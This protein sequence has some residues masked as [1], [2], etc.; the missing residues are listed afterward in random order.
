VT[1]TVSP[2]GAALPVFGVA[3]ATPVGP[4][5]LPLPGEAVGPTAPPTASQA[6]GTGGTVSTAGGGGAG[7]APAGETNAQSAVPGGEGPIPEILRSSP[8]TPAIALI[9]LLTAMLLGAGHAVTPGHGKTLMA[10]YLVGTRGTPRH[11]VGLGLAVSVSHTAGILALAVVVIGAAGVLPPDLVVRVAPLIAA[12]TILAIGG[13]MLITE[14]RRGLAGRRR[15]VGAAHVHGHHDKHEQ[16]HEQAHEHEQARAHEH[17]HRPSQAHAHEHLEEH[18]LEHSHG[19]VRHRHVPPAGATITWRSLFVLGLAGGLIPSTNA[20]LILLA[21][22]ASGRPAWGV[23]LVVAFGLGMA[24]VMT[25]VGLA[26]VYARGWLEG[27]G[28]RTRLA[29][30]I[31]HVPMAAAVLVLVV[32][33]GLTTQAIA[34]VSLR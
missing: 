6:P 11:A 33:I 16:A 13:W 20:L 29:G 7:S 14:L 9:A 12:G 18:D 28:T 24:G 2:G 27:M 4:I 15:A 1:F 23:V 32:G 34:T 31:R 5:E 26:F 8:V 21:T 30:L 17:E 3:D 25:G 22:I 10:A 19:G